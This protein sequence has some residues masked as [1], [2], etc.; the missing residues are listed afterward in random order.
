[1]IT[2]IFEHEQ[3]TELEQEFLELNLK[4]LTEITAQ[5][6][7]SFSSKFL[8]YS[9][10]I[11]RSMFIF[12]FYNFA[13]FVRVFRMIRERFDSI[14][15]DQTLNASIK[16]WTEFTIIVFRIC[17]CINLGACGWMM[18][19]NQIEE[20]THQIFLDYMKHDESTFLSKLKVMDAEVHQIY[21][22]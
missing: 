20:E 1:M 6:N 14:V 7:S 10:A 3:M 2:Q 5:Y 11:M 17:F 22:N 21:Y 12:K 13:R 15:V 19:S 4:E 18:F 16:I 9:L 8:S